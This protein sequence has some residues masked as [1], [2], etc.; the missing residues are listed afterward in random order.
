MSSREKGLADTIL[1][2]QEPQRL[3]E[4]NERLRWMISGWCRSRLSRECYKETL[5]KMLARVGEAPDPE[6]R[7]KL[8]Q[9]EGVE[10]EIRENTT[11]KMRAEIRNL[12]AA[13]AAR[14]QSAFGFDYFKCRG[15]RTVGANDPQDC[16]WPFCGCDPRANE[17]LTALDEQGFLKRAGY[18]G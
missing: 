6:D 3:R 9:S 18:E 13:L 16:N 11:A 15:C 14:P 5:D 2:T 10:N 12:R 8:V 17:V 7:G 1:E 4:E